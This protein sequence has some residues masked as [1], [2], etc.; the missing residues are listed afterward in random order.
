VG[1][2]IFLAL[3]CFKV[4][5]REFYFPSFRRVCA[6]FLASLYLPILR[7]MLANAA[8]SEM[9]GASA[10]AGAVDLGEP[11]VPVAQARTADAKSSRS[12]RYAD[13]VNRGEALLS[14]AKPDIPAAV[15]LLEQAVALNPDK[16]AAHMNLA[17]AHQRSDRHIEA[18]LAFLAAMERYPES[19]EKWRANTLAALYTLPPVWMPARTTQPMDMPPDRTNRL[20]RERLT[21]VAGAAPRMRPTTRAA[22]PRRSS[23]ALAAPGRIVSAARA[24]RCRQSPSG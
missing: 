16:P 20:T 9:A 10:A 18:S 7:S 23:R 15:R 6:S 14:K 11:V 2:D 12:S 19:T 5:A 3:S 8:R 1:L 17:I 21:A 24:R 4:C 13:M 22:L